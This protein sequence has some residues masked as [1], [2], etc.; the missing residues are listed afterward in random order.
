MKKHLLK[1]TITTAIVA[2]FLT[3]CGG[4]S[5]GFDP[6]FKADDPVVI[7]MPAIAASLTEETGVQQLDLLAGAT[8]G[9]QPLTGNINISDLNVSVDQN[10]QTPDVPSGGIANQRISPFTTKDGK[11]VIDTDMFS[12]FLSTCDDTDRR[13]GPRVN[14]NPTPDGFLDFPPMV[15]YTIGFAVDNGFTLPI[16]ETLPRRTLTL[17]VNAV[18][19]GVEDVTAQPARILLGQE[20]QLFATVLPAK[21][22]APEV[23]FEI[24]DTS[25]A[26]IDGDGNVTTVTVGQT[27]VTVSSVDD[28]TKTI[29]VDLEVFSEF[30]VGITNKDVDENGLETDTKEVP[31]CVSAGF[32]V[33][34]TPA[35]GEALSGDYAYNWESSNGT[36]FP[37][38]ENISYG[39]DGTGRFSTGDEANVGAQFDATVSLASGATGTTVLADVEAKN[40]TATIVKNEVCEPGISVHPAGFN[41][42]FKLDFAGAP[43]RVV[44]GGGQ[45]G[46]VAQ[47]DIALSGNS[48]EITAST[49]DYTAILQQV[50]NKQ[51]NWPSAEYGLGATS[52]G[53][54]YKYAVWVKLPVVPATEVRLDHTLLPWKYEDGPSGPGFSFRRPGAGILSATLKPTTEWQLLEFTDANGNSEWS[55]PPIWNVVTDVFLEWDVYGLPAGETIILDEYSVIKVN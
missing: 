39:E 1:S 7:D 22:C 24:A 8:S 16:G 55:V 4:T 5:E 21:A 33:S 2:S 15:T 54:T 41:T 18:F 10:Y 6:G 40:V 13:G 51:R 9:G 43:W 19:D 31:A 32:N 30:I 46:V 28:P 47:S 3:G 34:P 37:L 25:V 29:T 48:V 42:D 26:T 52:I 17:D 35:A 11:L 14:G 53:S 44:N 49:Q 23:A 36:D 38:A 50:F 27:T 45:G 20:F 12:D